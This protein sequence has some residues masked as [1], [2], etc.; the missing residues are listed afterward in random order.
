MTKEERQRF[1]SNSL[2]IL[3]SYHAATG[4]DQSEKLNVDFVNAAL[5]IIEHKEASIKKNIINFPTT[6]K[7]GSNAHKKLNVKN[8][9]GG[10]NNYCI[11]SFGNR[12]IVLSVV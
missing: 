3:R 5:K 4:G 1:L 6:F 12:R 8:S 9:V 7:R 11:C 10:N 2:K